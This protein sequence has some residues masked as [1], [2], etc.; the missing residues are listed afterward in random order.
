MQLMWQN[1]SGDGNDVLAT[2]TSWCCCDVTVALPLLLLQHRQ[3]G[4]ITQTEN[5]EDA[6]RENAEGAIVAEELAERLCIR[7]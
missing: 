5:S 2:T 1:V 4:S 6:S 3:R 7:H